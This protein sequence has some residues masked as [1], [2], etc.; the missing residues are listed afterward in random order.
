MI[1][2][3]DQIEQAKELLISNGA[4]ADEILYFER[5][6]K[7]FQSKSVRLF[8]SHFIALKAKAIQKRED[9]PDANADVAF[10]IRVKV[11][12]SDIHLLSADYKL[13]YSNPVVD[14]DGIR[15]KLNEEAPKEPDGENLGDLPAPS[16]GDV[17]NSTDEQ[18]AADE[19]DDGGFPAD[20]GAPDPEEVAKATD[21]L[22][23]ASPETL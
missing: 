12:F 4:N 18:D 21:D 20:E 14:T 7:D 2:I 8:A 1:T 13:S 23:K 11:D 22:P 16:A 5:L 9:D 6:T 15:L 19:V 17:G 10:N 3:Q